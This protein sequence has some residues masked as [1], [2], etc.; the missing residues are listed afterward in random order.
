M[1]YEQ[2][3][4]KVKSYYDKVDVGD[5][6]EHVAIEVDI[7]GEAEGAFYIEVLSDRVIV[8]P[9][10]YYD[11]D[12]IITTSAR[13]ILEI[14]SGRLDIEDA[15]NA[16]KIHV[17]GNLDKAYLLKDVIYFDKKR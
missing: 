9:Y 12:V 1:T 4:D 15:F 2:L 6:H 7:R 14:A 11:R 13:I 3:V 16:G 5:I 17:R 10:E 8:E